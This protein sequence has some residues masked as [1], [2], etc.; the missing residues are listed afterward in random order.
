MTSEERQ[1]LSKV[2]EHANHNISKAPLTDKNVVWL[3]CWDC[4]TTITFHGKNAWFDDAFQDIPQI[5][6]EKL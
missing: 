5:G 3:C 4:A 2:W 6:Q 1:A